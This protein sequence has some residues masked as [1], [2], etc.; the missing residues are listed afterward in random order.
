[1]GVEEEEDEGELREHPNQKIFNQISA[2][3]NRLSEDRDKSNDYIEKEV[4]RLD[5]DLDEVKQHVKK[6]P[7]S[8]LGRCACPNQ[9]DSVNSIILSQLENLNIKKKHFLFNF[10]DSIMAS[11]FAHFNSKQC[12]S[13]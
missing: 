12:E 5:K 9:I 4:S 8:N 13:I 7:A 11:I 10:L 1:M 2:D 6:C 3:V